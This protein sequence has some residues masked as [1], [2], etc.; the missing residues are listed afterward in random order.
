MDQNCTCVMKM[1]HAM[2][3]SFTGEYKDLVVLFKFW[4]INDESGLIASFFGV[5]FMS[6]LFELLKFIRVNLNKK[7]MAALK[8]ANSK[9]ATTFSPLEY[10][11]LNLI[12]ACQTTIGYFVMLVTMT[13]NTYLFIAVIAGLTI[14]NACLMILESKMKPNQVDA[15]CDE[16]CNGGTACNSS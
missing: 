3:M 16:K 10:T 11:A 8:S 5:F 2:Q 6:I 12:Y 13:Y 15:S 1:L 4:T 7:R 9:S 14:G